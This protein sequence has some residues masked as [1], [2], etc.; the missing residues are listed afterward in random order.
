VINFLRGLASLALLV[1]LALVV[2]GQ[3]SVGSTPSKGGLPFMKPTH[4]KAEKSTT[5]FDDVKGCDE[6]VRNST[7]RKQTA[8]CF[9]SMCFCLG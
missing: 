4:A 6:A 1:G 3:V 9:Q 8:V 7:Q 2:S 5:K